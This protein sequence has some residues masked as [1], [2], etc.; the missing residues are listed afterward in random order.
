MPPVYMFP[1]T[2]INGFSITFCT[3]PMVFFI[4]FTFYS[5]MFFP[6]LFV[7]YAIKELGFILNNIFPLAFA[8]F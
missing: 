6:E 1:P 8:S 3:I 4:Q 5:V 2:R 7:D